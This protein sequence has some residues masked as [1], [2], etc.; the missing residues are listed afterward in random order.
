VSDYAK[1]FINRRG[2]SL[3]VVLEVQQAV[4]ARRRAIHIEGSKV[5]VE[6]RSNPDGGQ[7]DGFLGF[8]LIAELFPRDGS[9]RA[10]AIAAV[11]SVLEA[12][13]RAGCDFVTAA[14]FEDELPSRGRN[15][16]I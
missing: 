7:A 15:V 16:P 14:E 5:D 1:V 11:S 3:G 10:D 4:A 6:I 12:L 13:H 2:G 8:P 9:S